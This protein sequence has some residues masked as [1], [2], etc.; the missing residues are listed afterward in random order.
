MIKKIP[1]KNLTGWS[2]LCTLF[3]LVNYQGYAQCTN[4]AARPD[5][6]FQTEAW[7]P[8]CNGGNDGFIK[9][10]GIK[11]TISAEPNANRP[12]SVRILTGVGGGLHPNYPAPFPIGN[13]TSYDLVNLPA[14]NYVVDIIDACGNTSADKAITLGQPANPE[15]TLQQPLII[16]RKT[17]PGGVCGDTFV[18]KVPF[19]RY[20]TGQTLSVTFT[21][22]TN[23]TYT[24]V[25]NTY[26]I[27]RV[28]NTPTYIGEIIVEVPVS[29][30]LGN[31][32]TARLASNQ[33]SRPIQTKTIAYP[34]SF[35][36]APNNNAS[37]NV[38]STVNTCI[39]GYNII[40]TLSYGTENVSISI[41]ETNNPSATALDINGNPLTF[42]YPPGYVWQD[43]IQIYSGLKYGVQYTITYK[44]ACGLTVVEPL[45]VPPPAVAV[46]SHTV[47]AGPAAYSP[48]VDDAGQLNVTLPSNLAR[49]FPLSF[50][51]TSGPSTW[52]ST[53]GETTVT[54]P[55]T[56][57]QVYTY[58]TPTTDG[59]FQLGT[60]I[61]VGSP[62]SDNNIE[63]AKQFAPGT[64]TI[65]YAD[66]CN[67][68]NIFTATIQGASCIRNSTTSYSI[69]YCN[70]TNGNVD[71][72]HII[73]PQDRD[74]RSLYKINA[75]GTETLMQ[76]RNSNNT[77]V[78]FL[79]V[80]P[81]TYK[82]RFGGVNINKIDYP[83]IGGING[84][85]RLAGTNYIYE[86]TIVVKPMTAL[87]FASLASCNGTANGVATGGQA[88]YTYALYDASGTTIVRP[89]QASG[90]F[91]GL[92]VG[93]TYQMQAID[94][95]GR[96]FNQQ[97][98][99]VNNLIAPV[100]A[101][102]VQSTCTN[103]NSVTINSLPAGNWKI[104]DSFNN[105]EITGSGTTTTLTSLAVGNHSFT[106]VN[107]LGCSSPA[108]PSVT[109]NPAP[110]IVNLV[111]TN[112]ATVCAPG[113]VNLTD[114]AV[115]AG[116][117]AGLTFTYF[118]DAAGTIPL[119]N[120][121]AVATSGTYYIKA[122]S[123]SCTNIKPV[124]VSVTNCIL[125]ILANDDTYGPINASA[126]ATTIGNVFD[127][128]KLNNV[129]L[130][131]GQ[132]LLTY[133]PTANL[134]INSATGAVTIAANTP[135]GNYTISYT[136]CEVA[137]S[138]NCDDATVTVQ[139]ILAC[140]G[141][142][143]LLNNGT[144][145][146][147]QSGGNGQ[148]AF[149]ADNNVIA[150]NYWQTTAAGQSITID[151]GQSRIMNGLTYYP[152]S[153]GSKVLGYTI[154][155]ST[156]NA[157]F[158]TVATGSF[159]N[160]ST[161]NLADKGIFNNVIFTSPVNARYLRMVVADANKR[162]AEI[163]PIVCGN[164]PIKI[165]CDNVSLMSS[166]SNA[167]ATDKLPVRSLDNNWT[168]FPIAG[169][170]A[171]PTTSAYNYSTISNAHFAPAVVVGK[172]INNPPF[173]WASSPFGNAE[174][175]SATQNGQDNQSQGLVTGADNT[176]PNTYF[177]KYKFNITDPAIVSSLKL[178]LDYYVDNN[179]VRV[180]VNGVDK[181]ISSND[182]QGYL[183]GHQRSTL[184]TSDFVL[185]AN[186]L[187][188][189]IF[190]TPGFEGLLVQGIGTCPIPGISVTKDG[191][192]HDT[193]GNGV[194]NVGDQIK[195]NFVVTNT[196]N[197]P[198]TNVTI[199]DN[200]ATVTGGPLAVLPVGASNSTTFTAIHTIT[201]ADIAAGFVYNLATVKGTDP[202][203]TVVTDTSSDPTPCASCPINP[204][205]P[206][207]TIT[208][209]NSTTAVDDTYNTTGNT[210]VSGN[211]LTNDIDLQGHTLTVTSNTS[212]SNGT[213]IVN[214]DGSFTYTPNPTFT[215][216]DTF[217]Y[218]VC[219]NGIPQACDVATVTINV[220]PA[221]D[222]SI[223]KTV[224]NATPTVGSN[225]T[226]TITA[227][228]NGPSAATG[229]SVTENIPTGYEVVSVT[230][231]TGSWTAPNW[232][233]GNLA[234]GASATLT[235]VAKVKATG[236]YANTV[237][238]SGN[239]TDPTPGNN[240]DTETPNPAA[241]SDLAI[242]KTVNNATPTVGSNVTFTITAT[243]NGPSAATGVS[244]T[245]N[246]PTGYEVVSVTPSTGS[247][248]APN[249]SIGNLAN[250]AS[251]TLTVV[252]KVKAIGVYANTV[253][254][255]GNETDPTPG[256]NT[257]TK[258]PT[259]SAV[260]DLSITK[261]VNN[262]TPTVGSNVTFTITATNNG[263]SAATG[264]S[265]TENIPTGY[266][267]VSVTPSTGSWTAPNWSI[268]NLANGASATLTVVAKVKATGVYANTV[269]ISGNETDP[270]PGNNTD[271]ETPNPAAVSD[272]AITKT[273]N[274]ATPT[275]GSNVTFTITAT[276][277]GPSAATGV[278]VTENIPTGYE[279]VSV[280][281]S[282]GS[283]TAPNWSI[284]NLANGASATLTV[285]AKVKAI[286]VYA[287]T[288]TISGNETDP[289][290]GNNTDT[291]EP[292]PSA[293]SD[294]SITKT[295]NN[296]TPTVGSNVTFTITATNNG[297]SNA[298]GVSVTENIPTGYE[299]VSVTPSTGSWTAPNWSI[300]NL[301]N[302]A[303][304]TL[305]VVA[306]VKAT[307]VY[308]NTVTISGNET[309]PTPGNNTDTE[310]PTPS[311]VSDLSITKTV[312][313]AT[314][315]V[316]SNVTFTITATNNG[317]SAAT[318][319][320][321]T[322]NIPTGYEVVS[323]T[324]STGSWTAPNWSIGNLANGASA[325]LTVVAK[326]KATGVY[327]NTVTISGNETD[328]T[329]GNNTDTETPNPAAVSDLAITKTVNKATPS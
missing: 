181:N 106:L 163:V 166:G 251:A 329:P 197:T 323:V 28:P 71:L 237:T 49:S 37:G 186:E 300:G 52:T 230:P 144:F 31:A 30:F 105:S 195:Y 4:S 270:T 15:F 90:T 217:T 142:S 218:T 326:V 113:A 112:P 328:P 307:G 82:V 256:N 27:P 17:S 306:K 126:T 110:T 314:P 236:V 161:T 139:V 146:V 288:V 173:V 162:V 124:A 29:F 264:V 201:A 292:T 134:S 318:G 7:N 100:I 6:G 315:T 12:Y 254:I 13:N 3:L 69:S 1:F 22:S 304:V 271:T 284:G 73:S 286:G 317:P 130:V 174:W 187:V 290:P 202:D 203:G 291:K 214:A 280:T 81:G 185:G 117:D 145:V 149:V 84:I 232:S 11:S 32:V 164:T 43:A 160:Y 118:T 64:Y 78:K 255:S 58:N 224:N 205:C 76:T 24:P 207:C 257:D 240:T 226:F 279:V 165:I 55:L 93:T 154:Q 10:T 8:T 44:D 25:S 86:E 94:A 176:M 141:E 312:N 296:A 282:T 248:T 298:T 159:P 54:A 253:T 26:T 98:V 70:Y 120:P 132:V 208:P 249:W 219:D 319:V 18:V 41:I 188:V 313:N 9:I 324:P 34:P 79:N 199:E 242:T 33:C 266:E 243:N 157:T 72:T 42:S 158:V 192:Y 155:A 183:N 151:Y 129:A 121:S 311:A 74:T 88:P 99:V 38:Q 215:G 250:G 172:V 87:S 62:L 297:P 265:V 278:S 152:S 196:G 245:E 194:T 321:V 244:V 20:E 241:V 171:S 63:R 210:P 109:L 140:S 295:V 127:N 35:Q 2:I 102:V 150:A 184:I 227:T 48:F 223:T 190:S 178:R 231:S 61:V 269:T 83:G 182:A 222:L 131:P 258:E 302:G 77:S 95:C 66:A 45:M 177:Y 92:T 204:S 148:Q 40:R 303:S 75:N 260:S 193:D 235:V 301:A 122:V 60:N 247:W 168:V 281:P 135:P 114:P 277:N 14:G 316:G 89:S 104:L 123:G 85:P 327:A 97:I 153:T 65:T 5:D 220:A 53:L 268:G 283:W 170:T 198:L 56:Y 67:R 259:P 225:V 138:G 125:P 175:I 213:V 305:T 238:I 293:V 136:I 133:S 263:P 108:S 233:I 119:A 211:V 103:G 19:N 23:Q 46:A 274:N 322:E 96:T 16:R 267:V 221:T 156:D 239:E 228:N 234:N 273:V 309:D 289:T 261:T 147:T 308:A 189:Q 167:T 285:V 212:P 180:Y 111:I 191:A 200:N 325:T 59:V 21:N 80:E 107:E 252:A 246:I 272:L 276:N 50:T 47:C 320:S 91:T 169:G 137:N 287:N 216:T 115:T 310:E 101:T 275:V 179:I 209:I 57:P 116:S 229:V 51:I 36:V 128:D 143:S 299:V 294:L 39:S 68:T 206:D 262:A